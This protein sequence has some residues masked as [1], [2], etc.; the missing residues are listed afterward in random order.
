MKR[1]LFA[2]AS[3]YLSL[4]SIPNT[5]LELGGILLPTEAVNTHMERVSQFKRAFTLAEVLITLG[6]IGV[7]AALT[8]PTLINNINKQDTVAKIKKAYSVF[9]NAIN[10][11]NEEGTINPCFNADYD[12]SDT[13]FDEFK[14]QF[15]YVKSFDLSDDKSKICDVYTNAY[16]S[17]VQEYTTA[18][19][20]TNDGMTYIF[21]C[22]HMTLGWVTVDANGPQKGPNKGG[23][24]V[25]EFKYEEE[26]ING[27]PTGIY[28]L[29]PA[30]D[31]CNSNY[32]STGCTA[33]VLL[34]GKMDYLKKRTHLSPFFYKHKI[35]NAAAIIAG[36]NGK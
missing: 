6:I 4:L 8:L 17:C 2:T 19:L 35:N 18:I 29:K 11:F 27:D 20:Q 32:I 1:D 5:D 15:N 14:K 12:N 7:V 24:D 21:N 22:A 9:G 31:T 26:Y 23:V 34:E 3:R 33:K 36:P 10:A 30:N 13:C 25:F 28:K 16:P